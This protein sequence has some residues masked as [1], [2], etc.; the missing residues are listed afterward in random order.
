[1]SKDVKN[2][3]AMF[4]KRNTITQKPRDAGQLS[5]RGEERPKIEKLKTPS[6]F[7]AKPKDELPMSVRK[8]AS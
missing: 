3:A 5:S 6:I 2:M 4:E 1:M 7:G 8:Q